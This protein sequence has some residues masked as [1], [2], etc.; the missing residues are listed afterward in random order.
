MA[1]LGKS[2]KKLFIVENWFSKFATENTMWKHMVLIRIFER[3]YMTLTFGQEILLKVIAQ[4]S[5]KRNLVK[6]KYELDWAEGRHELD[7][8][9]TLNFT[10]TNF[11]P[12]NEKICSIK[13]M[14]ERRMD[15]QTYDYTYSKSL[16]DLNWVK[17]IF[18]TPNS[19]HSCDSQ[20]MHSTQ[21]GQ[22]SIGRKMPVN[23]KYSTK[24][25]TV[26]DYFQL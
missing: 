11:K 19:L 12:R 22:A 6:V 25:S 21:R 5:I 20:P 18:D 4:P 7:K 13:V 16:P 3:S 15:G 26:K 24:L 14:S 23:S 17:S 9:F 10:M 8:D 2:G 1:L